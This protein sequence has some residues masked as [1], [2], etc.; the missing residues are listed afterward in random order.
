MRSVVGGAQTKSSSSNQFLSQNEDQV[1]EMLDRMIELS[2]FTYF[3]GEEERK[4]KIRK[5]KG[6][7]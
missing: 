6:I 2:E 4:K 5:A 3:E 1:M 7:C